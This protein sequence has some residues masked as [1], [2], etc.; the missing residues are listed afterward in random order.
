MKKEKLDKLTHSLIKL[1]GEVR[2]NAYAPYS[3]FKVGAALLT[4]KKKIY[5]GCNVENAS[6][7]LTVC[8]ER[9]ALFKALSEKEKEFA[10]VVVVAD[11]P[12]P[13][14]P[15]GACLQVL[16]EF[17]KEIDIVSANLRGNIIKTKLS[18]ISPEGFDK[19]S[20][21]K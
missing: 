5:T 8:A 18:R 20:L 6:F 19:K 9:V 13:V 14:L 2:K 17:C 15:C 4:K 12:I 3:K 10:K 1:A 16:K 21:K 11:S 7:G